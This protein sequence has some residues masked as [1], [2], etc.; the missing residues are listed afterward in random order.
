MD[1]EDGVKFTAFNLT[2]ERATGYFDEDGGYVERKDED[3]EDKDA[4]L[5][6]DGGAVVSEAVRR[7]IEARQKEQ[8]AEDAVRWE[9]VCVGGQ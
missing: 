6:A 2:E 5:H 7:K 4:W 3:A 9:C 1:E 8:E